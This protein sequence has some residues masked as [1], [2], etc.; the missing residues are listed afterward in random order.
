MPESLK[1]NEIFFSIQG[2]ST[3]AGLPCIFIRLAHCNLRCNYCDTEYAFYQGTEMTFA[4]ILDKINQ[5]SCNLVEVT[6]GEPLL[7]KNVLP[8][9]RLLLDKG[10]RVLVETGGHMDIS[11]I[12]ER[13]VIIMDIKCPG[14]GESDKNLWDNIGYLKKTDQV[15]FV[16]SHRQ[17]YLWTKDI[18]NKYQL[19]DN[20][21]VLLSPVFGR[22]DNQELAEW[23][24]KD[25]LPVRLQ[26]QIHKYIWAPDRR[27]V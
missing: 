14:S 16:I 15:K 10:R 25:Q 20:H 19:T 12:D 13:A 7:Q 18:I 17:D 8:F 4:E 22:I 23:I 3:F 5:Y 21:E 26:L 9:I 2:E 11:G 27:G 6:G 1:I 24:I